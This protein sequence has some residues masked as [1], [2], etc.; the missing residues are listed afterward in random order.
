MDWLIVPRLELPE[1]KILD[2]GTDGDLI[3]VRGKLICTPGNRLSFP[4]SHGSDKVYLAV[5]IMSEHSTACVID[6]GTAETR[7][8]ERKI[9][10]IEPHSSS[11]ERRGD[12]ADARYSLVLGTLTI[13]NHEGR[14]AVFSSCFR[15]SQA[16]RMVVVVGG[17]SKRPSSE[18]PHL[19]S[20]G[21]RAANHPLAAW[22]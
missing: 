2:S 19:C 9:S 14:G 22:E 12:G 7:K 13:S 15:W 16:L 4:R 20:Q 1:G 3:L 10:Q 8:D 6:R 17:C 11:G 5:T 21:T 18:L